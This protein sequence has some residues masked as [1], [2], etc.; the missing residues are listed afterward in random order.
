MSGIQVEIPR[1]SVEQIAREVCEEIIAQ[2]RP[3]IQDSQAEEITRTLQRI[4]A[5]QF[6]T[7]SELAYLIGCSRGYID[8][9]IERAQDPKNDCAVPYVDLD[10]LIQ[11]DRV[12]VLAWAKTSKPL[13]KHQ[14]KQG[15]KPPTLV[16]AVN[17]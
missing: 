4:N 11:F 2:S 15:G 1:S 12:E 6:I 16:K 17:Q 13:K 3:A 9:L 10:G 5:K 7:I 8:K 14:R